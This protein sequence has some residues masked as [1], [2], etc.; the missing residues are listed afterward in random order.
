[1]DD[2]WDVARGHL[3]E[4]AGLTLVFLGLVAAGCAVMVIVWAAS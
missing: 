1:M 2:L 3:L 4:I